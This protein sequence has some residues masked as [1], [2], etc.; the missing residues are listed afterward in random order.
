[1]I[2]IS[3]TIITL[4]EQESIKDAIKSVEGLVDEII[5]VDSE[6]KD[7]TVE[8]A[9]GLG[10]KVFIRKF[11]NFSNQKN[12]ALAQAQGKWILALDA[13]EQIPTDLA[14]EIKTVIQEDKYNAFLIPRRNFILGGEIKYTRWSPDTHIWLWK[15]DLGK[16]TRD[17]HEEV[18]VLGEIGKLKNAKL[19]FSHRSIKEFM[20]VNN[21]YSTLEANIL[22]K[23]NIKFSLLQMFYQTGFE[24]CLRFFYKRGFLDGWR[25]FVLSFLM[26]IYKLMVWIKLWELSRKTS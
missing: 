19:H 15:K 12:W 14:R 23:K 4:N 26:G 7:K 11:D 8:I 1:M 21:K 20:E 13:D 2:N 9:R 6:S 25:G 10:A 3:A 22:S 17:V 16:W 24:F 18:Q 5:L